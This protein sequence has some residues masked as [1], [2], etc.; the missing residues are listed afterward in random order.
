MGPGRN[1]WRVENV[2]DNV[3]VD[4]FNGLSLTI[5]QRDG[6]WTCAEVWLNEALGFG[7][8]EFEVRNPGAVLTYV[9]WGGQKA[10][11]GKI[12]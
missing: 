9:R 7:R 2:R 8:Y 12:D 3:R 11:G 1:A 4:A 5:A 10:G 6:R